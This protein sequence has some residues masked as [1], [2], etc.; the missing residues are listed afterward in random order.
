MISFL[1]GAVIGAVTMKFAEFYCL[2][3][4]VFFLL[5]ILTS[6]ILKISEN[7]NNKTDNKI[8]SDTQ[9]QENLTLPSKFDTK[10]SDLIPKSTV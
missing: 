7:N 10:L 8:I 2:V 3:I 1:I 6:I 5:V 9:K 4:P